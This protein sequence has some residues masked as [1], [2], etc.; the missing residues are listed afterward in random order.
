LLVFAAC[1]G[2]TFV[3]FGL[4]WMLAASDTQEERYQPYRYAADQPLEIDPATA[5]RAN[6]QALQNRAPCEEPKGERESDLCAQWRAANAAE[7]G[8]FWTKWGFWIA[9]IGSSLLLWQIILTRKAVEDTGKATVAMERQNEIAAAA[10]RAWV[11]IDIE[12]RFVRPLAGQNL[13]FAANIIDESY[14]EFLNRLYAHLDGWREAYNQPPSAALLPQDS[15][16]DAFDASF[17][18]ER[19]KWWTWVGTKPKSARPVF[20]AAV[21]YRTVSDPRTLH[22]SWRTWYLGTVDTNGNVAPRINQT[23]APIEPPTLVAIPFH[24][25]LMHE[26]H[27]ANDDSRNRG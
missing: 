23:F 3:T 19:L 26:E 2:L 4:G 1:V 21:I 18:A 9:T 8:A 5:G 15:E 16:T 20:L 10:Q 14:D 17:D 22:L 11:A 25:T 13:T 27:P 7:D 12:P 6:P 24:T